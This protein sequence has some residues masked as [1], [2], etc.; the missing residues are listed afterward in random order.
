MTLHEK[1][2]AHADGILQ[3]IKESLSENKEKLQPNVISFSK[4]LHLCKLFEKNNCKDTLSNQKFNA[5]SAK[6]KN[7]LQKLKEDD[8]PIKIEN[9]QTLHPLKAIKKLKAFEEKDDI[10][11]KKIC[12]PK[13]FTAVETKSGSQ[14]AR[15]AVDIKS[16]PWAEAE[17]LTFKHYG[18]QKSSIWRSSSIGM[19]GIIHKNYSQRKMG[20]KVSPRK[21]TEIMPKIQRPFK[22]GDFKSIADSYLRPEENRPQS[23]TIGNT[24]SPGF[25]LS[26]ILN[27]GSTCNLEDI[28]LSLQSAEASPRKT[29]DTRNRRGIVFRSKKFKM[30]NSK[31]TK[32]EFSS[33]YNRFS[34]N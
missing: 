4:H 5:S 6:I 22:E 17:T 7:L 21:P 12:L 33:F 31:I 26:P 19:A 20:M 10:R 3:T 28:N 13:N 30:P 29:T 23:I 14:S 16:K 25:C 2:F 1:F 18:S 9:Y 11:C 32:S 24:D 8:V 34:H 27:A 15:D